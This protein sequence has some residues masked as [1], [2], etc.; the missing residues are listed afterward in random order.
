MGYQVIWSAFKGHLKQVHYRLLR[1]NCIH[2]PPAVASL[3]F[4]CTSSALPSSP[5][6]Q[7]HHHT[8]RD[9]VSTWPNSPWAQLID[10]MLRL[11]NFHV[12]HAVLIYMLH[13]YFKHRKD[14]H[15]PPPPARIH[16]PRACWSRVR[17]QLST[18]RLSI[19]G[20]SRAS[21]NNANWT[22]LGRSTQEAD[23]FTSHSEKRAARSSASL[24]NGL[25]I[26]KISA[27]WTNKTHLIKPCSS[28]NEGS[29]NSHIT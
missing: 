10:L 13:S 5:S 12:E 3:V 18:P 19:K 29:Q 15:F 20:Y 16:L 23:K 1:V 4:A 28:F 11:S 24:E 27:N 14:V 21:L 8:A 17:G 6:M 2:F 7:S 22:C 25:N 9:A 26:F